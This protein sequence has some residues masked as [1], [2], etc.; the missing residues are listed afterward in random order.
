MNLFPVRR[1]MIENRITRQ[2]DYASSFRPPH[3][4]PAPKEERTSEQGAALGNRGSLLTFAAFAQI[5]H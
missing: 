4:K 1:K 5:A 2:N 3:K